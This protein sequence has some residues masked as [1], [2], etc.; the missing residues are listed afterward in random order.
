MNKLFITMMALAALIAMA[1]A[2]Q[3][4]S[5]SQTVLIQHSGGFKPNE[6]V[7]LAGK[8]DGFVVEMSRALEEFNLFKGFKF[9][10][11]HDNRFSTIWRTSGS[12]TTWGENMQDG[13]RNVD[14]ANDWGNTASRQLTL[15]TSVPHT[16]AGFYVLACSDSAA[17]CPVE[18]DDILVA[19]EVVFVSGFENDQVCL[20]IALASGQ[21]YDVVV[22]SGNE[23]ARLYLNANPGSVAFIQDSAATA[24]TDL[25]VPT[26]AVVDLVV[27]EVAGG[28][29]DFVTQCSDGW[30]FMT[31][32]DDG[33]II[34]ALNAGLR[35]M[36]PYQYADVCCRGGDG[37]AALAPGDT[38]T[39]AEDWFNL[40]ITQAERDLIGDDGPYLPSN[41]DEFSECVY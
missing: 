10:E 17:S 26:T 32:K 5:E 31:R 4:S 33:A 13:A 8:M 2:G 19:T 20:N 40:C 36:T 39:F 29:D 27:L 18:T 23:A 37:R 35:R 24:I 1:N 28:G 7:N 12:G 15:F 16:R 34:D 22:V 41:T 25:A 3:V 11:V 30:G 38:V 6:Y 21:N 9:E 14:V